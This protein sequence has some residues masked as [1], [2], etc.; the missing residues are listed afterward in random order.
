MFSNSFHS[1]GSATCYSNS[2]RQGRVLC[3]GQKVCYKSASHDAWFMGSVTSYNSDDGTYNLDLKQRA[4]T[5]RISPP[6]ERNSDFAWPAGVLVC[7]HS[8]ST[9]SW[10][11]AVIQNYNVDDG[12]Y[13]LDVKQRASVD[14]MR[15]RNVL[16]ASADGGF[17]GADP[18][19]KFRIDYN[20]IMPQGGEVISP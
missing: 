6:F 3:E 14:K 8:E 7:Y 9:N 20:A 12:T 15:I 5:D 1:G 17:S 10:I 16:E 4:P 19:E 13:N 2:G 11:N 18:G